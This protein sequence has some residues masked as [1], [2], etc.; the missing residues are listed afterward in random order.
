MSAAVNIIFGLILIVIWIIA[1][2]YVTMASL[3][4]RPYRDYDEKF[5]R[6]YWFLFW[7]A[8]VTWTL[9]G[10]FVILIIATV[11]GVAALFGTGVGEAATAGEAAEAGELSLSDVQIPQGFSWLTIGFLIFA[12]IL[13]GVTGV[14]AAAA[15]ISLEESPMFDKT[16][17]G[18]EKAYN[19]AVIAAV[20]ASVAAGVTTI[21]LIVYAVL[22][23]RSQ[24]R[25]ETELAQLQQLRALSAQQKAL[26]Q[27][28][29]RAQV[30]QALL[31]RI[32]GT[33]ATP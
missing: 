13:V 18:Q 15:A 10:I 31:Q 16:V 1:G 29:L 28:Q 21:A 2:V 26:N 23:W 6:A 14:L 11:V 5:H 17:E 3:A 24:E 30:Q 27:A 25:R 32:A 8:F 9:V 7:A 12:I 20:V 4:L 22:G 19:D 33:N